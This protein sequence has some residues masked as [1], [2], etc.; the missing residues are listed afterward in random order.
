MEQ[1]DERALAELDIVK[2][3]A[4]TH[5]GEGLAE[6]LWIERRNGVERHPATEMIRGRNV[7]S[8]TVR[9]QRWI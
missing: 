8:A 1:E 2:S 7:A 5:V 6:G 3:Y 4:R 9:S